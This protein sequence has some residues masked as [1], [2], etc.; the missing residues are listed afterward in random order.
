MEMLLRMLQK[1]H[2]PK[3]AWCLWT[4]EH[5]GE[6]KQSEADDFKLIPSSLNEGRDPVF[7]PVFLLLNSMTHLSSLGTPKI[8]AFETHT[9]EL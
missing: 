4:Q 6:E 7:A 3:Q 9:L 8:L 5:G 2:S 1:G